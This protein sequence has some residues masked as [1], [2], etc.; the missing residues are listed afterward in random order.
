MF[1][2]TIETRLHNEDTIERLPKL[3]VNTITK[4]RHNQGSLYYGKASQWR[5]IGV[6]MVTQRRHCGVTMESPWRHWRIIHN[7]IV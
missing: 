6:A 2:D 5:Y 3:N 4:W 7:A 1:R